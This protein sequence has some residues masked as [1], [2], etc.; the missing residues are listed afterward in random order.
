VSKAAEKAVCVRV[1]SRDGSRNYMP[2]GVAV[3][4]LVRNG[5]GQRGAGEI[6]AD[7]RAGKVLCTPLAA[8]RL[9]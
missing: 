9:A 4:N 3:Q 5:H 6:A 1:W 7:L 2:L 8:F